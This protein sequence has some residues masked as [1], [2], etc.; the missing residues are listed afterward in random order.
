VRSAVE[1][2][3]LFYPDLFPAAFVCSTPNNEHAIETPTFAGVKSW[4][5]WEHKEVRMHRLSASVLFLLAGTFTLA[6]TPS[7]P[8]IVLKNLPTNTFTGGQTLGTINNYRGLQSNFGCPVGFTANRQA[9][10]QIMSADDARRSGPTQGLHLTLHNLKNMPAIESIEVTVYGISQKGL[11][12][13]VGTSST[14]TVSKTFEF[15]R[16]SDDT[17][18]SDADVAMHLAGSLSWVD[19]ISITYANGNTWHA[20]ANFQCRAIP[21]NF[22][23]V[24]TR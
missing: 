5:T 4:C 14:D 3:L 22:L 21:S 13:P 12:L 10:V 16:T 17:S 18:L 11:V 1:R 23:L 8:P 2:N 7:N 20:T 9:P 6:Q 24:G 19:L 15:H